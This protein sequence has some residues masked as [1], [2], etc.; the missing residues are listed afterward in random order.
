MP[1]IAP[2]ETL[3]A[4][5]FDAPAILKR[6]ATSSR[7]LAELKGVA[8]SIPNQGILINTL[9]LQEAKDSSEIE[10][11]VTTHDELYKD[12]V[13]P[14]AFANP[15]AKEVLRYRQ[16][17]RVGFELVRDSGLLTANHIIAIQA[18]LE[19]NNAGFR[20]LPG[21]ALKDGGGRIVYTPPQDPTEIADCMRDLERFINT[22]ELLPVDPLIRMALI[23]HQFESIHPFYDGN[24]RTGRIVNVLCL[25]REQL[26]DIPVLYL[27]SHIVRSKADYYRLLQSVRDED[28]WEDWVLYML[29]AVETTSRQTIGTIHA[30]KTALFDYKHRIRTGY[31]F[32]SQDLINNLFMHPYTKIEFV[33]RDLGVS[34]VTATRYL[35][36][37]A[38]G[39]FVV[40]QRIGRGNYYINTALTS[41]LQP[42]GPPLEAPSPP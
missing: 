10:N 15:A 2:L 3:D 30:I 42:G 14:E 39:G 19:R 11:I 16:A 5:R 32:Y 29:E 9:G 21:T 22:P 25:V 34:R 36:A 35:E 18:E 4:A 12:D 13:L 23:H 6:L 1:R 20:K 31:K 37:L 26:L 28:T 7:A 38:D 33:Q 17:L 27:S 24:G 41:A 8:A 40:K